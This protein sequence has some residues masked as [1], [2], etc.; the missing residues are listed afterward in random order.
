MRSA[1]YLSGREAANSDVSEWHSL[2]VLVMWLPFITV[3]ADVIALYSECCVQ[4]NR[5]AN[6]CVGVSPT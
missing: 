2:R 6:F 3:T 5:E 1:N 4:R